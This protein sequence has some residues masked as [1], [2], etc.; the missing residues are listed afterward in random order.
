M[1]C[2]GIRCSSF[3][4]LQCAIMSIDE[5]KASH[6]SRILKL[7]FRGICHHGRVGDALRGRARDAHA[8]ARR[9]PR[10]SH[11]PKLTWG[12]CKVR[13]PCTTYLPSRSFCDVTF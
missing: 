7:S 6:G 2:V 5:G 4:G 13:A 12:K 1:L 3:G 11:S 8:S 10:L 9:P